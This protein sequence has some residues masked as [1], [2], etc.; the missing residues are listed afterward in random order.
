M[1]GGKTTE[2]PEVLAHVRTH[3]RAVAMLNS[4]LSV[5]GARA[6]TEHDINPSHGLPGCLAGAAAA[7]LRARIRSFHAQPGKA[8]VAAQF[9]QASTSEW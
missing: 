9:C 8:A 2:T 3:D 6:P 5:W 7:G 1:V 4:L